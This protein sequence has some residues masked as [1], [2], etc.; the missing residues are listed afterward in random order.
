MHHRHYMGRYVG[1]LRSRTQPRQDGK[2][3]AQDA[4]I[5]ATGNEP[6]M[7]HRHV[8]G[9]W[10]PPIM[11]VLTDAYAGR[12]APPSSRAPTVRREDES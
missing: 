12:T 3:T 11:M 4:L 7:R 8:G 10:E 5:A 2:P 6:T 9:G 1:V